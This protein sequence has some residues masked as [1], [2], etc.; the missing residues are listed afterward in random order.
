MTSDPVYQTKKNKTNTYLT[1][2]RK[3]ED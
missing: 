3:N 1:T 2:Y